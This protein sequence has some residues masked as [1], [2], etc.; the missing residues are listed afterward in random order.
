M[1]LHELL[2]SVFQLEIPIELFNT[3]LKFTLCREC[4]LPMSQLNNLK[5]FATYVNQVFPGGALI[6]TCT[7]ART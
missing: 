2:P 4:Y 5:Q 7:D 3:E 6:A 1:L